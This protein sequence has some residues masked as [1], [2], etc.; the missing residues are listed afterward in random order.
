MNYRYHSPKFEY[1]NKIEDSSWPWAGHKNF[2]YDVV[3][4]FKPQKIV[5][6]GTHYGTSLW[7][8]SQAVKDKGLNTE[9]F[10]VDT[11]KGEKH[12][13]FY[14]EDVF[15]IV[16]DIKNSYYHNLKIHLIRKRFN[17]AV[18]D[19]DDHSI[20][21]LHIDGLHT[22]DAVKDDFT[23]WLPKMKSDGIILFHDI[24]V[25][26]NDFGVYKLWEELKEKYV[27]IEFFHSF[28]LGVLF[29]D[30][31]VGKQMKHLEKEWQM[32][33]S[34]IHEIKRS[35]MIQASAM[36][37]ADLKKIVGQ[38]NKFPNLKVPHILKRIQRRILRIKWLQ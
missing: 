21:M 27:T 19:F 34:Y 18:S 33:Y 7:S 1:E 31:N 28:G 5:E 9:L 3:A 11:W 29:I 25:I 8:F 38:K 2:A 6:L 17:E 32:H 4:N 22:Y 10:A 36:E 16:K 26:E 30:E 14:G 35:Q 15:E 12:A 13:G 23:S 37:V 20:D 24:K